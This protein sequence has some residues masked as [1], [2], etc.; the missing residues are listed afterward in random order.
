[1]LI[2]FSVT[3]YRSILERQSLHMAA[4]CGFKKLETLNTFDPGLGAGLPRLLRQMIEV[5]IT[6]AHPHS[7]SGEIVTRESIA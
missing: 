1:M 2:E 3:N 7:L 5:R 4:S 6:E